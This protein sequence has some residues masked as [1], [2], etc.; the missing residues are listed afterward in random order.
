M[1]S[2]YKS[3]KPSRMYLLC[4]IDH[5]LVIFFL[6]IYYFLQVKSFLN[7]S[8]CVFYNSTVCVEPKCHS[9]R[10]SYKLKNQ[11]SHFVVNRIDRGTIIASNYSPNMIEFG[12]YFMLDK[13]DLSRFRDAVFIF[14]KD[15]LVDGNFTDINDQMYTIV[16]NE[17][18]KCH[19]VTPILAF[20]DSFHNMSDYGERP[21]KANVDKSIGTNTRQIISK[22]STDTQISYHNRSIIISIMSVMVVLFIAAIIGGLYHYN[23]VNQFCL[24]QILC[25]RGR[26]RNGHVKNSGKSP[27][28]HDPK[29]VED[30]E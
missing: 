15:E 6:A 16:F 27:D 4:S 24:A 9:F 30:G 13:G 22:D 20:N 1:F 23:V 18:E 8:S 28:S 5:Q 29:G 12:T 21:R 10:I 19:K 11:T 17:Q 7:Y 25:L 14:N 26:Q 2:P 3:T